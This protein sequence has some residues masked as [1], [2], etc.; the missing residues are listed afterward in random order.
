MHLSQ[1][2]LY[3]IFANVRSVDANFVYCIRVVLGQGTGQF[4]L[5]V[6]NNRLAVRL[7]CGS[8][9]VLVGHNIDFSESGITVSIS[10]GFPDH[11]RIPVFLPSGDGVLLHVLADGLDQFVEV[12]LRAGVGDVAGSSWLSSLIRSTRTLEQHHWRIR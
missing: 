4:I 7:Q 5:V 6:L 2:V 10:P 9:G 11:R 8:L 12:R 3:R 1:F